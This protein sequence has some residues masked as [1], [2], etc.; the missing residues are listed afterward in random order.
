MKTTEA[1]WSECN[2]T[3]KWSKF[4]AINWYFHIFSMIINAFFANEEHANI[5]F[6]KIRINMLPIFRFA[7]WKIS[8]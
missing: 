8:A 4:S 2:N 1:T 6:V 3:G 7:V 5:R